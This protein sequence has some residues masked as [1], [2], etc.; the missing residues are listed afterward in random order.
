MIT[1]TY[2]LDDTHGRYEVD[3][4]DNRL[5]DIDSFLADTL[6]EAAAELHRL[7]YTCN[8]Q[9]GIITQKVSGNMAMIWLDGF[10]VGHPEI[11]RVWYL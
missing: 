4:T 11:V 9:T 6:S 5:N 3:I 2:E 8:Q 10:T 1:R 7:E